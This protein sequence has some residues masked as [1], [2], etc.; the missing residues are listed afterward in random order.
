V[1]KPRRLALLRGASAA[2]LTGRTFFRLTA[3]RPTRERR[4]SS[5]VWRCRCACGRACEVPAR[6]LPGGCVKSCSRL[7]RETAPLNAGWPELA[8]R[9][10]AIRT[11]RAEGKAL[12][13]LGRKHGLSRQRIKQVVGRSE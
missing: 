9:D 2:D 3:L 8:P 12:A 13:E 4:W 6:Q 5:V 7:R 11:E 10:A 1:T